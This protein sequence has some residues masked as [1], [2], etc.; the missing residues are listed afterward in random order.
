MEEMLKKQRA[1]FESGETLPVKNRLAYLK[2][3]RQA[4]QTH[5]DD[6]CQA[7]YQDLGKSETEAYMCEIGMTLEEIAYFLKQLPS[8]AKDRTVRTPLSNFH[9]KS[10]IHFVPRGNVLILSPWNYPF[11]LSM[12]PLVDALAA[13]NTAVLKP[14]AYSPHTSA[15]IQTIIRETFPP[16]YVT[17][18]TGGRQENQTLLTQKFDYIFFTGSTAVGKEVLR[19]AAEN[20]TPVTLEL[21]G[22]SPCL[23]DESADLALAARRIVFGKFLNCGQTCVA[24]DYILCPQ[25]LQQPLLAAL[26]QEIARQFGPQPLANPHYG[27]I[28][29]EKHFRRL[30]ALLTCGKIAAGGKFSPATLQIEPTV[31]TDVS[32]EEAVMQEEIFGPIL[33]IITYS[34]LQE[35]L[36]KIESRP[37]PLALYLFSTDRKRIS[38][39]TQQI[40]YGGGCINDTIMHLSTPYL[41]FGGIGESGMGCYHGKFGFETFSHKKSILCKRNWIDVPLRYQPYS[42]WKRWLLK[43]FLR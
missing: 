39:I 11:L 6:I 30:S 12:E 29:N 27:K 14:S 33:P 21:G 23:V 25:N 42:R 15:V 31:L 34:S 40:R 1:F 20:L 18:V 8:L 17:T 37:H 2:K 3:L 35:A 32:W 41:P 9:A 38:Q 26:R 28:I 19:R 16:H 5:R 36:K 43:Y 22:K 7:L 4:I 13:G 10:I 24:P